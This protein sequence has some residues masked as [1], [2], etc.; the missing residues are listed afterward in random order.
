[1]LLLATRVL[2]GSRAGLS[3]DKAGSATSGCSG[4]VTTHDLEKISGSVAGSVD[5][6]NSTLCRVQHKACAKF[7]IR[8]SHLHLVRANLRP[9]SHCF[10]GYF[11]NGWQ[12][13]ESFAQFELVNFAP[14]VTQPSGGRSWWRAG[15]ASVK[16]AR[17]TSLTFFLPK[18]NYA[19]EF[20]SWGMM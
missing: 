15:R 11:V 13:R 2:E 18:R 9:N 20:S 19:M 8:D 1:V 14:L 3:I 12:I 4:T 6:A 7:P 5:H 17:A 16:L 10:S